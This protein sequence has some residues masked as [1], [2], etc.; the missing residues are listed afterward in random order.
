[1][2]PAPWLDNPIR[3]RRQ[4]WLSA[5]SVDPCLAMQNRA[6]IAAQRRQIF[7]GKM[8]AARSRLNSPAS[9]EAKPGAST[10]RCNTRA[11]EPA[12]KSP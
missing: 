12:A 1:M 11:P 10:P 8:L 9:N 2:M 7:A 3:A 4:C 5:D 6:A